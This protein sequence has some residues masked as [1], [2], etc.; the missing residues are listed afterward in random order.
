MNSLLH[1]VTRCS[2]TRLYEINLMTSWVFRD[3]QEVWKTS[4][5]W[6]ITEILHGKERMDAISFQIQLV[7]VPAN[8]LIC[9][10]GMHRSAPVRRALNSQSVARMLAEAFI[11]MQRSGSER[12]EN[13]DFPLQTVKT[14]FNSQNDENNMQIC[15]CNYTEIPACAIKLVWEGERLSNE[16]SR[17]NEEGGLHMSV[18]KFMVVFE[19][20]SPTMRSS[21]IK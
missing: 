1:H 15:I 19:T 4:C 21:T 7:P 13:L 6:Y 18:S 9:L 20:G 14:A 10:L 12:M 5:S 11:Q 3:N 2:L 8:W 17:P 16:L